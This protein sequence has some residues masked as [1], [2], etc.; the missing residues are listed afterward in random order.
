MNKFRIITALAIAGNLGLAIYDY[1][2]HS[3]IGWLLGLGYFACFELN[4]TQIRKM[5]DEK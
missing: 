5:R 1:D 2:L 3:A 4:E